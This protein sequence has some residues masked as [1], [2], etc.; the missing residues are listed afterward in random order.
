VRSNLRQLLACFVIVLSVSALPGCARA[1]DGTPVGPH[2]AGLPPSS[3]TTKSSPAQPV[4]DFNIGR[5]SRLQGEFPPGFGRV[6]AMPVTTL[7]ANADKFSTIGVGDIVAIDPTACRSL[8]QPVRAPRDA[9]FTMVGGI[10]K[11]VIMVGAVNSPD[12]LPKNALPGGCDH[13]AVT[14]RIPGRQF[15]STVTHLPG[16]AI[17]GA[18]TMGS[19]AVAAKGGNTSYVF[20]AF[21]SDSVAV[22]VQG[23]IPGNPHAEAALRGLLIKAVDAVR[24]A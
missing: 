19:M 11:G 3:S 23:I 20:A 13:V 12:P 21:L 5:L 4:K 17:D 16:P 6:R 7:G 9:Q 14:Q 24:A 18:V 2:G 8:L 10:G 1:V 22:A 15:D